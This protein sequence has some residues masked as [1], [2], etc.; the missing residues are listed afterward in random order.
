MIEHMTQQIDN[1]WIL[2][3]NYMWVPC[4]FSVGKK[5]PNCV[6]INILLWVIKYIIKT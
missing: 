5:E 3:K 4:N 6:K 1:W 2:A